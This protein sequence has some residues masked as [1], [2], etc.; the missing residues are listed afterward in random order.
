MPY[1][2]GRALEAVLFTQLFAMSLDIGHPHTGEA[3]HGYGNAGG[4]VEDSAVASTSMV[5]SFATHKRC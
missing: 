2:S 4:L 1:N 5:C 3:K